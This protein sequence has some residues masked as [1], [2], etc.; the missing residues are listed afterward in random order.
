MFSEL[1]INKFPPKNL[2]ILTFHIHLP[3]FINYILD[4]MKTKKALVLSGGSVKGAFQA[5]AVKAVLETGF[6][7]EIITGISVGSLN[8]TFITNEVGRN[9]REKPGEKIDWS[10]IG[11][12]LY[13]FWKENI[14]GPKSIV[15]RR[16]KFSLVLQVAFNKFRGV[17]DSKPIDALIDKVI[18]MDYIKYSGIELAVGTANMISG[19]ILYAESDK[20]NFLDYLKG[21]KAIPVVMPHIYI[22][23]E[24]YLDGGLRDSAPLRTA[25]QKGATE[26]ICVLCHS[27]ELDEKWFNPNN[28]MEL[29]DRIASIHSNETV[30]NDI[31]FAE[32]CNQFLPEDG[33]PKSDEPFKGFRKI[34]ITTIRPK[35]EVKLNLENFTAKEI[36]LVMDSGYDIAKKILQ[37]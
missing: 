1:I 12:A 21:S 31:Q 19:K 37:P 14:T 18:S 9:L 23:S 11:Q 15:K 6:A 16:S 13:D 34:K 22:D 32:Y 33:S 17:T 5:G 28:L 36:V 20:P 8:G 29:G 30:N 7:P 26:I 2:L 25:I 27:K 10:K 35:I 4:K 24:P 3:K